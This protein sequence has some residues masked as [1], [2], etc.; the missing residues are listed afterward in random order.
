MARLYGE[1]A[2]GAYSEV[3]MQSLLLG[4]STWTVYNDRSCSPSAEFSVNVSLSSCRSDQFAC[5]DGHCINLTA[6]CDGTAAC[7]DG[8]DE[9][10]CRLLQ[11]TGRYNREIAPPDTTVGVRVNVR[12]I[13]D[14]DETGGRVRILAQLLLDW[15]DPRLTFL[16]LKVS[17]GGTYVYCTYN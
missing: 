4:R 9:A 2:I 14:I 3:S 1:P 12:D 11:L 5:D 10:D 15:V 6:R 16:N 8:S 13:L 7:L 17:G